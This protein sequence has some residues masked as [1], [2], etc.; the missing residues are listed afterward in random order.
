MSVLDLGCGT[1]SI[2]A[3]IARAVAPDG[4]VFGLDRDAA[5]LALAPVDAPNLHF[6]AGEIQTWQ[7]PQ[8]FD[9]VTAA[10]VLQWIGDPAA[11]LERM[12]AC[13]KPRGTVVV[14][15]YN[16]SAHTWD[17]APPAAFQRFY[18]AFLKWRAA[19]G[20]SNR[21]GD[22]LPEM[23]RAAGLLDVQSR[24]EDETGFA[25][26]SLLWCQ[27]IESMGPAIVTDGFLGEDERLAALEAFESWR[28]NDGCSVRW[29]LR[30]IEGRA[31]QIDSAKRV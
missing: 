15:D 29:N 5:L 11:A 25:R 14:L 26:G 18:S 10:R 12:C 1:G 21:I 28:A 16:H 24:E 8:M 13:L 7:P 30:V 22:E 20:W 4:L 2:T 6:V 31:E 27:V 17:P 19:N 9:I 23:F 3:G